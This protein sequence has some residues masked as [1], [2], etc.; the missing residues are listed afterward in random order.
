MYIIYYYI[1]VC[2]C[3]TTIR[4]HIHSTCEYIYTLYYIHRAPS[5]PSVRSNNNY[6]MNDRRRRRC[7]RAFANIMGKHHAAAR[8][9]ATARASHTH[10]V[11]I[12]IY[13]L[14]ADR[15]Q[16]P[17]KRKERR[18]NNNIMYMGFCTYIQLVCE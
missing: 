13:L 7:L 11:G 17:E 3:S 8:V 18:R 15:F 4:A 14:Y 9:Y 1:C 6:V 10:E 5:V 12:L 2:V 16:C